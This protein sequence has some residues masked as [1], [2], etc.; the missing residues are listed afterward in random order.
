[1]RRR[2]TATE[3]AGAR[4]VRR[5]R[6]SRAGVCVARSP[7]LLGPAQSGERVA[8][9]LSPAQQLQ[10]PGILI[11]QLPFRIQ[12]GRFFDPELIGGG[13]GLPLQRFMSC[14]SRC[15]LPLLDYVSATTSMVSADSL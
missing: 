13:A 14:S 7:Q 1:M 3:G 9:R 2:V 4:G 15:K 12:E 10:V 5:R 8:K 11:R 6:T